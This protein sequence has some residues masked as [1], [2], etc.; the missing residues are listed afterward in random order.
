MY[1]I[2]SADMEWPILN[3]LPQL[4]IPSRSRVIEVKVIDKNHPW[5]FF[6][7]AFQGNPPIGA[8][9]AYCISMTKFGFN[10]LQLLALI[11]TTKQSLWLSN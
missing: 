3:H 6:D 2:V 11:P 10:L 9:V 1:P 7:G 5:L 4:V 8:L